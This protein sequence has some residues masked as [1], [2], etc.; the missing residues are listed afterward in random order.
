MSTFDRRNHQNLD[1]LVEEY[2]T[3]NKINRRQFLKRA[4]AAGLSYAELCQRMVE[5]ARNRPAKS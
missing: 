2:T 4:A 1:Q 5:L 3:S